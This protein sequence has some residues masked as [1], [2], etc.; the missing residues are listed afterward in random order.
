MYEAIYQSKKYLV[1]GKTSKH[2]NF[3]FRDIN[4]NIILDQSLTVLP[5][6]TFHHFSLVQSSIH[7]EWSRK[8]STSQGGTPRYN[9]SDTIQT[10]P[11]PRNNAVQLIHVLETIGKNYHELRKSWMLDAQLGLTKTFNL[12]HC[13][14]IL[15]TGA[16]KKDKQVVSLLKHLEKTPNTISFEDAVEGIIKLRQLHK[17]MDEAVLEAYGM[18][19]DDPKWGKAIQLRHDFYEVDYLPENDRV[20]YTIH[21]EARKE[22]LKRLLQ[23]NHERYAE[24]V[25]AGLHVKKGAKKD[26]K[27]KKQK[28]SKKDAPDDGRI[29]QV[30]FPE[31]DL[32]NQEQEQVNSPSPSGKKI[33]KL[34]SVVWLKAADGKEIKIACGT[35]EPDAQYMNIESAF[36]K[37]LLGKSEGDQVRFRNGFEVVKV[38]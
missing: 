4:E 11:F 24:E 37:A 27:E 8:H 12:F 9:A 36:V 16:N 15:K 6:N 14:S 17:Q 20:R 18:H 25:A 2:L 38:E 19:Q 3:I 35:K 13:D 28:T 32:F 21:P 34:G 1:T 22:V 10:F 7:N 29:Q 30:L 26:P 5:I 33:V 31:P 23:L